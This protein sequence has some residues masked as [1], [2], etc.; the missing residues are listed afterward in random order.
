MKK[1]GLLLALLVLASPAFAGSVWFMNSPTSVVTSS[2]RGTP[3]S[4]TTKTRPVKTSSTYTV[5]SRNTY[6][7]KDSEALSALLAGAGLA[8]GRISLLAT[9]SI[10]TPRSAVRSFLD[11]YIINIEGTNYVLVKDSKDNQWT[12][13]NILGSND[14]KDDLFASL[15]ALESDGDNTKITEKELKKANIRFVKL[16]SDES[17]ALNDR[18]SDF[19]LNNVKYID[20]K[21]LRT[22]LGNKNQDGT[23]G[24]FYVIAKGTSKYKAYPG[25]VTFEDTQEL[26]RYIK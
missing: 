25:R 15:K 18:T 12:V 22:A 26:N 16:N 13:D 17:L 2:L 24:Y 9:P 1:M 11:P 8:S 21:N 10:M 3:Y 7:S 14:S 20:I 19:D 5:K 6:S 23:F 4:V